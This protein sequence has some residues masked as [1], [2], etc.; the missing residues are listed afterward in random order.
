VLVKQSPVNHV[1]VCDQM[2]VV[3]ESVLALCFPCGAVYHRGEKDQDDD[4]A[5]LCDIDLIASLCMK[6]TLCL[7]AAQQSFPYLGSYVLEFVNN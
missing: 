5:V 7:H 2:V 4:F 1:S 6:L 3:F